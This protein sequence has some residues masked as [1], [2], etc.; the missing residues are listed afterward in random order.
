MHELLQRQKTTREYRLTKI[1]GRSQLIPRPA[2][3][4]ELR[5]TLMASAGVD[6]DELARL[7]ALGLVDDTGALTER[8]HALLAAD[9]A[10]ED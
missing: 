3:L 6:G 9:V 8:A 5:C 4:R 7:R 1:R 10:D 2:C